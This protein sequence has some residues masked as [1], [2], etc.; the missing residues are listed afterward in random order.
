MYKDVPELA[1]PVQQALAGETITKVVAFRGRWLETTYN[2][3]R[4]EQGTITGMVAISMDITERKQLEQ[5]K[6]EFLGVASHE[7]KT[8]VTSIKGYTQLLERRF[9][10]D[11]DERSAGLLQKMNVQLQ[12]LTLL[13]EDLLDVT[14]LESGKLLFRYSSF[15]YN[16]LLDE[17][18]EE[19]QRTTTRHTIIKQLA[20][21]VTLS[22]DRDRIGQVL[23]N[24]LTNAIKYSPQ[25]D[26]II[27]RTVQTDDAIVTSV[28]DFGIGIAAEKQ[29]HIFE[30]FFRVEGET[31]AT[32]PGL[33]LGLYI[34]AE[35]VRRHHGSIW[36]ES[37]EGKGTTF[38]FSLPL[39]ARE[40][41]HD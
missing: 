11:G 23:S 6:D 35:F 16:E 33:G 8:P 5:L 38:S 20:P 29:Q 2:P 41:T 19:T 9:R 4:D 14:R 7:L 12:K 25:A 26:T 15:D 21:T 1:L 13:I 39:K 30:R 18:V 10:N 40:G 3:L 34:A 37:E 28:R 36:V 17:I 24:L 22:A 31:L 27:V 32:Y